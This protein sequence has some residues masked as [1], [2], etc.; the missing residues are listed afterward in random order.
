MPDI[1]KTGKITGSREDTCPEKGKREIWSSS[2]DIS[3]IDPVRSG[4]EWY[5]W[6]GSG[7]RWFYKATI[8]KGSRIVG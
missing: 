4:N 5:N 8:Y 7:I 1:R 2:E 3:K 6:I